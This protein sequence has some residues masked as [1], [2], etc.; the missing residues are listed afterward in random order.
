MEKI[1]CCGS[2]GLHKG[3]KIRTVEQKKYVCYQRNKHAAPQ[4]PPS[5]MVR[6]TKD[7]ENP[8]E[9][10]EQRC[11]KPRTESLSLISFYWE[12]IYSNF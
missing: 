5:W 7:D 12:E 11:R 2:I 1:S 9:K 10:Q 6:Q 3:L 8:Q 4:A